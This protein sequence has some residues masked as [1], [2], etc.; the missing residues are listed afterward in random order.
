MIK[1]SEYH[2]C[3]LE[4]VNDVQVQVNTADDFQ[5][6]TQRA[7]KLP[8]QSNKYKGEQTEKPTI[9]LRSYKKRKDKTA[10]LKIGD[11]QVNEGSYGL[12]KQRLTS[13]NYISNQEQ[14]KKIWL[15]IDR[16]LEDQCRQVWEIK[17]PKKASH[18]IL[19]NIIRFISR[20]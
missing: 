4:T 18:M 7:W 14:C 16:L 20:I 10:L 1:V 12:L 19:L 2:R 15:F 11:R 9:L 3:P 6:H 17:T 8:Q 5:L 13:G